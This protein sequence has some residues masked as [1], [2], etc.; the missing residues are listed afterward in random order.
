[1][2]WAWGDGVAAVHRGDLDVAR[3]SLAELDA[4]DAGDELAWVSP[5]A[6]I[7]R[8]TLTAYVRRAEGDLEAALAAARE[9]ADYEASLPVDFGP[10]VSY[11]PAREL[12]ADILREMGRDEEASVAYQTALERTPNRRP[13]LDGGAAVTG[14]AVDPRNTSR[15]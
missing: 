6:P 1:M 9:A 15:E 2:V 14:T 5:Y 4:M 10:P 12:E 7:W 8:G 3:A 13:A 11:K